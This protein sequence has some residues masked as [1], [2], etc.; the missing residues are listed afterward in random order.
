VPNSNLILHAHPGKY[1]EDVV[2]RLE[3]AGVA[4]TRLKFVG[5]QPRMKYLQ[6]YSQIDIGLDP[7]PYGGGITTCDA[8]W[9]GVPVVTLS[10]QTA[11]GRGGRSILS[12]LGLTERIAFTPD[13]YV[14]IAVEL[15]KDS[16]RMDALR[17]GLRAR[18]LASPLMDAA[19]F[20]RD[21]EAVYRQMWR[22]WCETGSAKT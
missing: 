22:A 13:Q 2:R 17:R 10:G 21:V 9:M 1:L 18:V 4:K 7:F 14:D 15:A 19:G 8:L 20:A 6:T 11:V 3:C 12:N 5:V 16:D